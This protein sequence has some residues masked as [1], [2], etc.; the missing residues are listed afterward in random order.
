V[1]PNT[2]K[3][4][5]RPLTSSTMAVEPVAKSNIGEI[6]STDPTARRRRPAAEPAPPDPP[7]MAGKRGTKLR[8]RNRARR[9]P[10]PRCTGH[11][12]RRPTARNG[13]GWRVQG[14]TAAPPRLNSHT[15]WGYPALGGVVLLSLAGGGSSLP[16]ARWCSAGGVAPY[17]GARAGP[18]RSTRP[19][20]ILPSRR[21]KSAPLHAKNP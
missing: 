8:Y 5:R 2:V 10:R 18:I 15:Y 3:P 4:G 9:S 17:S 20:R 21:R 11:S 12:R 7:T 13:Q 14:L 6:S 16:P 19:T 1:V